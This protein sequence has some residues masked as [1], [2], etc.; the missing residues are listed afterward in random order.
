MLIDEA[1]DGKYPLSPLIMRYVRRPA[2]ADPAELSSV[3]TPSAPLADLRTFSRTPSSW[4]PQD[5]LLLRH[6]KETQKL[7]WKDIA[8]HFAN[9]T[10]NACQFRWRRL[11]S[12][13]LK[14]VLPLPA[15]APSAPLVP[16][17]PLPQLA[18]TMQVLAEAAVE[19]SQLQ[20]QLQTLQPLQALPP[21]PPQP[22]REL[23]PAPPVPPVLKLYV[24]PPAAP[25]ILGLVG[26][27]EHARPE[28][29]SWPANVPWQEDEDELLRVR[30]K[31][32]LSFA[33]LSILLPMRSEE[34]IWGRIEVLEKGGKGGVTA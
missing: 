12:G 33:E 6:L 20:L 10:P 17:A 5:D 28:R 22:W 30:K 19:R 9:R 21:Q 15:L 8:A 27:P 4:D 29:A 34:D 25:P 31:R 1:P 18:R 16:L 26:T 32:D 2:V 24:V 11:R 13:A 23:A 14:L 7:G 3:L